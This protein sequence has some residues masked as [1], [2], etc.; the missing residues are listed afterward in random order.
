MELLDDPFFVPPLGIG[1]DELRS[2]SPARDKSSG[3]FNQFAARKVNSSSRTLR[4]RV[5]TGSVKTGPV[6]Y[7]NFVPDRLGVD[8]S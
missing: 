1:S 5:K 8:P 4:Y 6:P 7:L 3:K 2:L